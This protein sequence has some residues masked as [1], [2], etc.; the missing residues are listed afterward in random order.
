ME[1]EN[2]EALFGVRYLEPETTAVVESSEDD[3]YSY[4]TYLGKHAVKVEKGDTAWTVEDGAK[5]ARVTRGPSEFQS[6]LWTTVIRGYKT[7]NK[8]AG[9]STATVLPYVNGCSTKQIFPPD[10]PG[11]PT[12]QML[13]IPPYSSEQAHHIHSTVRIVYVLEGWGYSK[14]GMAD[15]HVK[16]KLVP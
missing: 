2:L 16:K 8:T 12:L 1:I 11:D 9:L 7:E 3:A 4:V 10:R 14:V 15:K 13:K 5:N 6:S